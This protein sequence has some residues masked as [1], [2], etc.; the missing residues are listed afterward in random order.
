M[1]MNLS[2]KN[3]RI[4][5]IALT[6]ALC[7]CKQ[8]SPSGNPNEMVL[9]SLLVSKIKC[10][11]PVLIQDELSLAVNSQIF[12]NLYQYHYLKRPYQLVPLLAEG[13]PEFSADGLTCMVRIKK[14]VRFQDD[15]CFLKGK[16]RE[17]K[18][19]DFVYTIKRTA[20]IK[21]LSPNWAVNENK[22]VGLLIISL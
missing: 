5:V 16:G 20:D 6:I 14:G 2:G 11:D 22:I 19:S 12:E 21:T 1:M 4:I 13:M 15:A 3:L 18:A 10:F 17:L 8:K 9:H 7:G